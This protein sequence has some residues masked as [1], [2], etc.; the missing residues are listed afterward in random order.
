M[1]PLPIHDSGSPASSLP[2]TQA[3]AD[4]E[5]EAARPIRSRRTQPLPAA[6][7]TRVTLYYDVVSPW[8]F[9]AYVGAL[10]LWST[11]PS[12]LG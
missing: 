6:K 4:S 1:L 7:M 9:M 11:A 12:T 2:H 5:A 3:Q 8:S 10:C